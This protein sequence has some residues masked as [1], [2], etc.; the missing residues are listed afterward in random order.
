MTEKERLASTCQGATTGQFDDFFDKQNIST[1]RLEA[2]IERPETMAGNTANE[3]LF[4]QL[5]KTGLQNI[6]D[7]KLMLSHIYRVYHSQIESKKQAA[8]GLNYDA[9]K[10]YFSDFQNVELRKGFFPDTA[11]GMEEKK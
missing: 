3:K 10:V 1:E 2:F 7:R 6:P 4:L 11:K 5:Y 8:P 9:I